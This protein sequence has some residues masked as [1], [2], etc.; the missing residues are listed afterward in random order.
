M[1]NKQFLKIKNKFFNIYSID[2]FEFID[3]D[4]IFIIEIKSKT[5][6][7]KFND[8]NE[9]NRIKSFLRIYSTEFGNV[10]E[11]EGFNQDDKELLID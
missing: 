9:Y 2:Y 6:K 8:Q 10:N 5:K 4:L 7:F 11:L 1:N 3:N